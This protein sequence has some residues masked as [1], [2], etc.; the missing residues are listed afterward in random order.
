M[1]NLKEL[2]SLKG[3]IAVVTGG[4]GDLGSEYV[5]TLASAGAKVVVLDIKKEIHPKIRELCDAGAEIVTF[6]VDLTEK[7]E[8]RKAFG[9]IRSTLRDT[10]SILINNAGRATHPNAPKEESGPFEDYPEEVWEGMLDSH[11]KA[12][13]LASQEF[14]RSYKSAKKTQ[15]SIINVSSTYGLVSPEQGMY[16]FRRKSKGAY[17]KPIGYSVAKSGMLGF[18]KW[19]AEYCAFEKTGI[20]VNTLVPGG[21]EAGQDPTFI[22]EYE[23]RTM[24]GRM[25]N[26]SDYNGAILFLASNASAYMT[27]AELVVDGGWTA[28]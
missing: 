19:L 1:H 25:A 13:L 21:V 17:Y 15:G 18:T 23:K 27:G 10:P 16:E 12:A 7:G 4:Q 14:I 2:F 3:R 5:K 8:V 28:R 24:L 22:R 6:T 20:R 11:L 9:E 26:N